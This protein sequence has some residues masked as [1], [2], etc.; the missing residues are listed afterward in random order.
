MGY[1]S[2]LLIRGEKQSI[3]GN[4][5]ELCSEIPVNTHPISSALP[6]PK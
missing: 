1:L 2:F 5:D 3:S 4:A 6:V